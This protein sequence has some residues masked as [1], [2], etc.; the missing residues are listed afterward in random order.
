MCVNL[1]MLRSGVLTRVLR[2]SPHN[3]C[4]YVCVGVCTCKCLS[5]RVFVCVRVLVNLNM[6]LSM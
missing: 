1:S 6:H 5:V 3:L 2:H 4:A